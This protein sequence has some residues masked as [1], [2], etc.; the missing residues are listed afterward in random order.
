VAVGRAFFI[1]LLYAAQTEEEKN[2]NSFAFLF[3]HP[4]GVPGLWRLLEK[5]WGQN[6][7]PSLF[8]TQP[9]PKATAKQKTRA[10]RTL[11][12]TAKPK[13]ATC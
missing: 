5:Y 12:K 3:V 11:K 2:R 13:S 6:V 7:A 4:C 9:M 8:E 10:A 1:A